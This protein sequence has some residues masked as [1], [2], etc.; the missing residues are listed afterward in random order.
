MLDNPN[1]CEI[2]HYPGGNYLKYYPEFTNFAGYVVGF[3]TIG[4][5]GY[6]QLI[7]KTLGEVKNIKRTDSGL[8]F[9]E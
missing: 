6:V 5:F 9:L 8:R 7:E 4:L 3:Y 1:W 2:T